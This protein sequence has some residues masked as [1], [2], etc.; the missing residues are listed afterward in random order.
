MD[1]ATYDEMINGGT[2]FVAGVP[3]YLQLELSDE[4]KV[5]ASS[6]SSAA[7]EPASI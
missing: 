3:V 7:G 4:Y 6:G 2:V 5:I 1:R